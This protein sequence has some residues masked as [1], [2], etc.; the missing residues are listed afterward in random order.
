[1]LPPPAATRLRDDHP[2]TPPY[3]PPEEGSAPGWPVVLYF[4]HVNPDIR[5][6]TAV[7]P[8][9]FDRALGLLGERFRPLDPHAVPTVTAAGG[10]PEP[11]CLLTFDDGYTDVFEHALPIMERRGWRAVMF[12]S[13]DMVGQIEDH[14]VR[15]PLPHMTWEQL[16]E[17]TRRGHVVASHGRSHVP[18]DR[19]DAATAQ[20]EVDGARRL[21]GERLPGTP[22][23]L[24][25]PFGELPEPG[26]VRLPPLCFGSIKAP[27]RPWDA[28]PREIRRTYLPADE[29]WRWDR[30]VTEWRRAWASSESH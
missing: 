9:A 5:H 27:A 1:M 11:A 7:T 18:F 10:H 17:L 6:Y 4:H 13:V 3:P 23:W 24:A 12:V 2:R 29:P 25:Y 16:E 20:E 15:G 8:E 28:A 19:L 26:A 21:L 14:P 22:D 30:C